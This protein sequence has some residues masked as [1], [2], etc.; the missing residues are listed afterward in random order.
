MNAVLR[1]ASGGTHIVERAAPKESQHIVRAR[2]GQTFTGTLTVGLWS[3][4]CAGC[5][6]TED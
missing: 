5:R 2:C 1:T 6:N 3:V 4:G